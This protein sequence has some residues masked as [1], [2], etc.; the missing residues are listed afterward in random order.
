[1][2]NMDKWEIRFFEKMRNQ[3]WA[4]LIA[5]LSDF[6]HGVKKNVFLIF[7]DFCKI[8]IFCKTLKNNKNNGFGSPGPSK[9]ARAYRF[10]AYK[11][12]NHHI[13]IDF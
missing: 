10:H 7:S 6:E 9:N 8:S 1:M 11:W 4:S 2:E 5:F 3:F 12:S 13:S